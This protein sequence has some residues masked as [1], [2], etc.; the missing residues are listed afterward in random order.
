[1]KLY[2]NKSVTEVPVIAQLMELMTG[3]FESEF[4]K[5]FLD[6]DDLW[7]IRKM[8]DP[9]RD[10]IDF[11]D[12]SGNLGLEEDVKVYIVNSLYS[13]KG[14]PK[15]FETLKELLGTNIDYKY[16][17]PELELV[18]FENIKLD[19]VEVFLDKFVISLTYLLY[20]AKVK[21]EIENLELSVRDSLVSFLS[22]KSIGYSI[23]TANRSVEDD[24]VMKS[25]LKNPD[26]I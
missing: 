3:L 10:L 22:N 20:F 5:Q 23:H 16:K 24:I 2:L 12:S 19:N 21:V 4:F 15:I 9:V 6:K 11:I 18:R 25:I 1:M 26:V 13:S 8:Y 7:T 17:F 14:A